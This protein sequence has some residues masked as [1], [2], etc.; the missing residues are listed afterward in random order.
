[1]RTPSFKTTA[2]AAIAAI[3]AA[4]TLFLIATIMAA[5]IAAI[6]IHDHREDEKS[7][8]RTFHPN[9]TPHVINCDRILQNQLIFEPSL[10]D[11]ES[12]NRDIQRI[13]E[14]R[15]ACVS[16]RWHPV[17]IDADR[18]GMCGR[19][20]LAS[21][22]KVGNREIP[23]G[24][25]LDPA[26]PRSPLSPKYQKDPNYNILVHFDDN[27]RLTVKANCWMYSD[28]YRTWGSE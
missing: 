19:H 11:A 27:S 2:I 13:Q 7:R 3:A 15:Q 25:R 9:L 20:P 5:A 24:L 10:K 6:R 22:D 12:L 18:H 28:K 17:I 1:M 14:Q 16:N 21:R 8:L 26:R 23:P 4:T